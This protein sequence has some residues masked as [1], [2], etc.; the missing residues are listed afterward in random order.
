MK[1]LFDGF[2]SLN[3]DFWRRFPEEPRQRGALLFFVLFL[4]ITDT[5]WFI[6]TPKEVRKDQWNEP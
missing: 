5:I 6:L 3:W 4:F 2:R 1:H